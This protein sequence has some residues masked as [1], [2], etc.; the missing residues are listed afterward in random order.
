MR[1]LS[2]DDGTLQ[3]ETTSDMGQTHYRGVNPGATGDAVVKASKSSSK[4]ASA[5][6]SALKSSQAT[7]RSARGASERPVAVKAS[8]RGKATAN[9]STAKKSPVKASTSKA[10]SR[11]ATPP[12]PKAGKPVSKAVKSAKTAHAPK[13][14]PAVRSGKSAAPAAVEAPRKAVKGTAPKLE[15]AARPREKG[16]APERMRDPIAPIDTIR[17]PAK[18]DDLKAR[19][20][21]ISGVIAQLKAHKRTIERTFF[22]AGVLLQEVN[23]ARLFEVKGYG[24]LEAFLD[25]ETE[26]GS[27]SGL[28]ALRATTVFQRGAA[29]A[30]G[31]ARISAAMRALDGEPDAPSVGDRH[32]STSLPPHKLW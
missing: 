31:F 21:R 25:R 16:G 20:G 11:A 14:A 10:P 28:R 24:S 4:S 3:T 23:E 15:K 29:E 19:L 18:A 7:P 22:E 26:L 8:A 30:A 5:S 2:H 17:T 9:A 13:A 32:T 27:S 1:G 12:S 6:K